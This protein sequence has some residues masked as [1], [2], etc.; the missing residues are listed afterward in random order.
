M[1][2][3]TWRL[4]SAMYG[5]FVVDCFHFHGTCRQDSSKWPYGGIKG[6]DPDEVPCA[7]VATLCSMCM[8]GVYS[9]FWDSTQTS[10][11]QYFGG[12]KKVCDTTCGLPFAIWMLKHLF[13]CTS[14]VTQSLVPFPSLT[15]S[16]TLEHRYVV[17]PGEYARYD[18]Q[19]YIATFIVCRILCQ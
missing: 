7:P 5:F 4:L 6:V 15:L 16:S 17:T 3:R 13:L 19:L 11:N 14:C 1:L 9:K 8:N 2:R 12:V 18:S 10:C